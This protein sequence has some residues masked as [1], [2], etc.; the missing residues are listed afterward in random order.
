MNFKVIAAFL[1]KNRKLLII[2]AVIGILFYVFS[3]GAPQKKIKEE[4]AKGRGTVTTEDRLKADYEAL[5]KKVEQ[6][7][8]DREKAGKKGDEP[9]KGK[10]P[11]L[12]SPGPGKEPEKEK[13]ESL[14]ELEKALKPSQKPH[15]HGSPLAPGVAPLP[16]EQVPVPFKKPEPPRLLKIDVSEATPPAKK[17]EKLSKDTPSNADIFLPAG[18]FASFTLTSQAFAPETGAQMPV[19]GVFDKAFVGPNRSAVPLRGCYFLGKAQGNTGEGI[20]DIKVVKMSCVWPD[21]GSFE[22]DVAGYVTGINGDFGMKGT[23]E[24]HAGT[25]FST[26]GISSFISGLATGMARAQEQTQLGTSAYGTSTA[27]NVIGSSAEYGALKGAADF[28]GASKQFFDKQIQ[29]LIPTVVVPAGTQGY[30]YITSGVKITGGMNAL[31]RNTNYY[32]SYNL[33]RSR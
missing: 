31:N 9:D 27:T 7:E 25:F 5:R 15:Q 19:A 28:A 1:A 32:D 33:S 17:E 18:S 12:A 6:I 3:S 14:K 26:V 4:I 22:A 2:A 10:K 24:R 30:V 16:A 20:A 29:N 23:V 8:K 21:G 13:P 11:D